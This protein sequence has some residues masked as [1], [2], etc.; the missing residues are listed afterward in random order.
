[1]ATYKTNSSRN[2]KFLKVYLEQRKTYTS[3]YFV[4]VCTCSALQLLICKEFILFKIKYYIS[5][6]QQLPGIL[7]VI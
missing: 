6:K 5:K 7:E 4:Y 2:R 1:M 3:T